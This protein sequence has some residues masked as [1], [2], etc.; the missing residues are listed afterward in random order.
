M[1]SFEEKMYTFSHFWELCEFFLAI[2]ER[3]P[4]KKQWGNAVE[5]I[6]PMKEILQ[7]T[8]IEQLS[9]DGLVFSLANEPEQSSTWKMFASV[10]IHLALDKGYVLSEGF[11][12]W[13]YGE[14]RK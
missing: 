10:F 7:K 5:L 8:E 3:Q 13:Y 6:H 4:H 1:D 2:N 12:S 14:N 11:F 9:F